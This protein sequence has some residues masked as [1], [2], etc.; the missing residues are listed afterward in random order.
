V[1]D[2]RR[3]KRLAT[4]GTVL[5]IA[6]GAFFLAI[7]LMS[8]LLAKLVPR[9]V[10]EKVGEQMM[11]E[12]GKNGKFCRS[13]AGLGALDRLVDRLAATTDGTYDFKVYVANDEVLNAFA[14]PG[15]HIV[16]YR[17]II[18]E[19]EHPEE[20]AGVLSH[21][22]AHVTEGHPRRGMV[23]ALGY[24]VF[25]LITP[26]DDN[27]GAELV[28]SA[29]ASRY[30]RDDELAA[31]RVGV[32]M[33]N[34]AGIDSRGLTAFFDRLAAKGQEIPGALEFLS[35]HPAGETRKSA[36]EGLTKEGGP[37]MTDEEWTALKAACEDTGE[38]KAV[39]TAI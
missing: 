35:T 1:H 14:A 16:I 20:V 24:G 9:A 10:E 17:S 31:D 28:K 2:P 38:P 37:A 8:G 6:L 22:M 13:E 11:D 7:P 15:G 12:L 18:A 5:A 39:G 26:G 30:S 21:E 36:L 23:E 32:E 25:R 33:L 27:I 34:A 29:L 19:A 4:I 3:R